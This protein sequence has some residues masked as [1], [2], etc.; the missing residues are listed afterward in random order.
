MVATVSTGGY[1]AN[2]GVGM[3]VVVFEN[4]I[5]TSASCGTRERC[6]NCG[7]P[8]KSMETVLRDPVSEV[9]R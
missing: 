5:S 2:S 1:K 4:L 7:D 3:L 6:N 9:H 8:G